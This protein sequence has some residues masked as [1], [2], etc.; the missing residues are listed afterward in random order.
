MQS[1]YLA[2]AVPE[3]RKDELASNTIGQA[4]RPQWITGRNSL[5]ADSA[6]A[7]EH[8]LQSPIF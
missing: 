6:A 5:F 1:P 4:I 2:R 7:A 8:G 3:R